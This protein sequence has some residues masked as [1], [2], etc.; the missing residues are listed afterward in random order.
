MTR[1]ATARIAGLAFL[2]YIVTGISQMALTSRA[3]AGEGVAARLANIARNAALVRVDVLLTFTTFVYAVVLAVTLWALTR[4]QD[5]TLAALG[6]CFRLTEG[7][8]GAIECVRTL[9]LVPL[10]TASAS[11]AG[12]EREAALA[13]GGALL[14]QGGATM[15]I[16]S[17]SFALGSTFFCWLF[18]RG[19]SIPVG[20]AWLGLGASLLLVLALPVRIVMGGMNATL[21]WAL[22]MPILVFELGFAGWLLTKG[23]PAR[24]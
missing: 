10:A 14:R 21:A 7:V 8:L 6:L 20:L 18:L 9:A 3:T 16:A 5:P 17:L 22:W 11:A 13:A 2:L 24:A 23:M 15:P 1:A 19:R 12:P 4:D